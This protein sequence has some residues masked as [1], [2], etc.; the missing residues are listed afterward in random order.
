VNDISLFCV[1]K[2]PIVVLVV[3][4]QSTENRFPSL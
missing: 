2:L 1:S 3:V 4:F